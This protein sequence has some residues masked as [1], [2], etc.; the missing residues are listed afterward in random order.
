MLVSPSSRASKCRAVKNMNLRLL[1]ATSK[2]RAVRYARARHMR[3]REAAQLRLALSAGAV[4]AVL[5]AATLNGAHRTGLLTTA[6]VQQAEPILVRSTST[7]VSL[8]VEKVGS[9]H[10]RL[11]SPR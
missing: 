1:A 3:K 8:D 7:I 9:S 11:P 5:A 10:D 6:T 2:A 4:C